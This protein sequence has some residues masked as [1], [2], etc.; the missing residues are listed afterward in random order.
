LTKRSS[1]LYV[2][3]VRRLALLLFMLLCVAAPAQAA[4]PRI[5]AT[6]DSM[7]RG[8]D[9]RIHAQLRLIGEVS[10]RSDVRIGSALTNAPWVRM[11]RRQVRKYRPRATVVFLGANDGYNMLHT[12]CCGPRWTAK[13]EARV[14]QMIRNYSRK[15]RGDVYWVTMP[16]AR[17]GR[18][19]QLFPLINRA[20][21]RAVLRSGPKAHIVEAWTALTP[22]GHY[23]DTMLR[24]G[25]QVQLRLVDGVHLT[26]VGADIV[27][28]L[29][30]EAML[31][32]GIL[33]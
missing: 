21:R 30:R 16:A 19:R 7:M 5:L 22:H 33:Q 14:K 1:D 20:M 15:G 12:P 32:D 6:G 17:E 10:F 28:E 11:S 8:V 9:K 23:R 2:R 4:G 24:N 29:V 31:R 25:R 26:L 13:Y 3:A 18:R 27:A